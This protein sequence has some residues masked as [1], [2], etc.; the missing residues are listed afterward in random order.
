VLEYTLLSSSL[1]PSTQ[2]QPNKQTNNQTDKFKEIEIMEVRTTD[3]RQQY[4]E[5]LVD[6]GQSLL[7]SDLAHTIKITCLGGILSEIKQIASGGNFF[8][9]ERQVWIGWRSETSRGNDW[10]KSNKQIKE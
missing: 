6:K 1:L 4:I 5:A 10:S 8:D 3:D 2:T 7:T 9:Y